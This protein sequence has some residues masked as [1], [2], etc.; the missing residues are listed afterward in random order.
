M[1]QIYHRRRHLPGDLLNLLGGKL[2]PG[3]G[4]LRSNNY[5]KR[6]NKRRHQKTLDAIRSKCRWI[7]HRE[8]FTPCTGRRT[9]QVTWTDPHLSIWRVEPSMGYYGTSQCEGKS[10]KTEIHRIS[11]YHKRSISDLFVFNL[12]F[13]L[14]PRKQHQYHIVLVP[15]ISLFYNTLVENCI[16]FMMLLLHK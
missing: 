6:F 12:W 4:L 3:D 8:A 14:N 5:V 15:L 1:G 11:L 16:N 13:F 10:W 9:L 7:K 2:K